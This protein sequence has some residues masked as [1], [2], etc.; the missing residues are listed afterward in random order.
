MKEQTADDEK[1]TEREDRVGY[2]WLVGLLHVN[3]WLVGWLVSYMYGCYNT[4]SLVGAC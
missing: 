4:R 2:T 1:E 3:G